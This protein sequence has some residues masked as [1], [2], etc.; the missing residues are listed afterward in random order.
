[1]ILILWAKYV[2]QKKL[3]MDTKVKI[4]SKALKIFFF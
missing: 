1:M 3:Q 2:L 4:W